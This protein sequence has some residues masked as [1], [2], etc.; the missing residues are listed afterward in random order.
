M[1]SNLKN[2]HSP[3]DA[4][5]QKA[6]ERNIRDALAEDVGAADLTGLLVPAD[7]IVQA[8]VIVREDAIL[9]GAPWFDAVMTTLDASIEVDWQYAEGEAIRPTRWSAKSRRQPVLC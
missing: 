3:F 1:P 5:L 8:Q 6:F 9:C 7:E 2:S 4:D